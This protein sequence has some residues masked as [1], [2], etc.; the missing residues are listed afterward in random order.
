MSSTPYNRQNSFALFSAENP[1][2]QQS[3]ID[4]DAEFNAVKISLDDTQQNLA[5]IQ[6]ADGVL[7][8]GSVGR[9][10]F[11]SS[12]SLGFAAPAQWA[13]GVLYTANISTVFYNSIFYVANV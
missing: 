9:A 2:S 7:K 8:R 13:S 3:G 10:Q 11:D 12:V 1:T 5:K 6:D 4:L